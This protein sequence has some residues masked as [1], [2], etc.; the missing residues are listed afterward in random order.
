MTLYV[1]FIKNK[2]WTIE[3]CFM[4]ES[5][6]LKF[7]GRHWERKCYP[8]GTCHEE[9]TRRKKATPDEYRHMIY[10]LRNLGYTDI[11]IV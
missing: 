7:N 1:R 8:S 9:K 11:K 4:K 10:E 5:A 6:E 3:A 2:D